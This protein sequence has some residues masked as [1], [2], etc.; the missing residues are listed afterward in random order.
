MGIREYLKEHKGEMK[1][2]DFNTDVEERE[3]DLEFDAERDISEE[4]IEKMREILL[5]YPD[6]VT[7]IP[8]SDVQKKEFWDYAECLAYFKTL[9]PERFDEDAFE[10]AWHDKMLKF[11]KQIDINADGGVY[12][13][14]RRA[15]LFRL[16]F[17][18]KVSELGLT[19]DIFA[20]CM[21]LAKERIN[22]GTYNLVIDDLFCIS[23]LFPEKI[24]EFKAIIDAHWNEIKEYP[25]EGCELTDSAAQI[26]AIS[27]KELIVPKKDWNRERQLVNEGFGRRDAEELAMSSWSALT[28][29]IQA[30]KE[31]K[32]TDDGLELIKHKEDFKQKKSKRPERLEF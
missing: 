25:F 16:S 29:S 2:S 19:D 20:K 1:L 23:I 24:K 21:V 22:N 28:L 17:P 26:K 14:L 10:K 9:F 18:D 7:E 27:S 32:L 30:A 31:V 4:K 8:G 13:F 5:E 3:D 12:D 6:K 11:V 15:S